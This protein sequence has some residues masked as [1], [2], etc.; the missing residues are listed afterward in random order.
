MWQ[1]Q[2]WVWSHLPVDAS[3]IN[4]KVL[5]LMC[6]KLVSELLLNFTP[7]H[8]PS[9]RSATL[10]LYPDCA[11]R[12]RVWVVISIV[13]RSL[14]LFPFQRLCPGGVWLT[15]MWWFPVRSVPC[16]DG[17]YTKSKSHRSSRRRRAGTPHIA[18]SE[19]KKPFKHFYSKNVLP[20]RRY[21]YNQASLH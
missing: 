9:A 16:W 5:I 8:F 2:G 10:R 7:V 18:W 15:F 19:K 14:F 17:C 21:N 11:A 3:L 20:I 1:V 13:L 12:C 6:M 4:N